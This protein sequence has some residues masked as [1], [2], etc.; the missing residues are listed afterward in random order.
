MKQSPRTIKVFISFLTGTIAGLLLLLGAL[1]FHAIYSGQSESLT[2]GIGVGIFEIGIGLW[3][4]Y[5][6]DTKSS[7][8]LPLV[9]SLGFIVATSFWN[10]ED[11]GCLG[12]FEATVPVRMSIAVY[13]FAGSLLSLILQHFVLDAKGLRHSA[14]GFGHLFGG[15]FATL[16]ILGY[17]NTQS[18][19]VKNEAENLHT[20][21]YSI[22][23]NSASSV[24]ETGSIE[25]RPFQTPS[26][27]NP[28]PIEGL[29]SYHDKSLIS[30]GTVAFFTV[31]QQASQ[32]FQVA[33]GNFQ[34]PALALEDGIREIFF[35]DV[36]GVE[37]KTELTSWADNTIY[38]SVPKPT[39]VQLTVLDLAG[40]PISSPHFVVHGRELWNLDDLKVQLEEGS[41]GVFNLELP[42]GKRLTITALGYVE[43]ETIVPQTGEG[44]L[45][46]RLPRIFSFGYIV[47]KNAPRVLHSFYRP[48]HMSQHFD[49]QL[50]GIL[51]NKGLIEEL[52]E[53]K[54]RVIFSFE[55]LEFLPEAAIELELLLFW[56]DKEISRADLKISPVRDGNIDI[57]EP[58]PGLFP[59]TVE[60]PIIF[61]PQHD[62]VKGG[63]ILAGIREIDGAGAQVPT[64]LLPGIDQGHYRAFLTPGDYIVDMEAFGLEAAVGLGLV[65]SLL[66]PVEFHVPNGPPVAD[67]VYLSLKSG[68]KRMRISFADST[69]RER[70]AKFSFVKLP[71]RIVSPKGWEKEIFRF[72]DADSRY[73]VYWF[74][75]G[76]KNLVPIAR[77]L[78]PPASGLKWAIEL[79]DKCFRGETQ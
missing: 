75:P 7:W 79:P 70:S 41:H 5:K 9:L 58:D 33:D 56:R 64:Q 74:D 17:L 38:L 46:V 50:E 68:C 49:P 35:L 6:R 12:A 78:V 25:R 39:Q 62:F 76:K 73:A 18:G 1:K 2:T 60:V 72:I 28:A 4:L 32:D 8:L 40:N 59:G 26:G 22:Q 57:F 63:D 11:C 31:G 24:Q 20:S 53:G 13:L 21:L 71:N 37:T 54:R 47:P 65:P 29:I 51:V 44:K 77:D 48:Q 27:A 52:S 34:I 23:S 30:K 67:P 45:E 55:E 69:G 14:L 10:S 66:E 15:L 43:R 42:V 19:Q 36:N 16:V 3:L 61:M